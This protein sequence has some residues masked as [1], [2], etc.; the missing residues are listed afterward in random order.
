M[1]PGGVE[2]PELDAPSPDAPPSFGDEEDAG[3]LQAMLE[4]R[5]DDPN[6][7]VSEAEV[8]ATLRG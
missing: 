8:M 2:Y 4:V 5:I 3:L 7:F 1:R 6:E